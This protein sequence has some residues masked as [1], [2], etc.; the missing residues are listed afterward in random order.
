MGKPKECNGI[1]KEWRISVKWLRKKKATMGE[2]DMFTRWVDD[3]ENRCGVEK[4]RTT[5]RGQEKRQERTEWVKCGGRTALNYL[6]LPS[7]HEYSLRQFRSRRTGRTPFP[8]PTT[9]P[10]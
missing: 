3:D 9:T 7:P 6:A 10:P 2:K 5:H 8:V 4:G 1:R